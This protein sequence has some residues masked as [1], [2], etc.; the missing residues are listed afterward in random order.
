MLVA[1][2]FLLFLP[3]RNGDGEGLGRVVAGVA[4]VAGCW[5]L[6]QA[7]STPFAASTSTRL[8]CLRLRS[9]PRLRFFL[10][11]L[12]FSSSAVPNPTPHDHLFFFLSP[13]PAHPPHFILFPWR[14][15][16][17]LKLAH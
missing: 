7:A 15:L 9:S 16:L 12:L 11:F 13:P 6:A 17:L 5:I 10:F 4:M 2:F 14:M 3:D 8:S 1:L